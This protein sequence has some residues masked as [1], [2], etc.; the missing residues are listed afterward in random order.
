M[1]ERPFTLEQAAEFLGSSTRTLGERARKR[2]IP[3]RRPP[4]GRRLLFYPSE[5]SAWLD[6]A[7]LE[8]L[9]LPGGGRSVRPVTG[10]R[11]A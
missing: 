3:H 4:Y 11:P 10:S 7:P 1:S 8:V 5:L 6:G 2:Q 9:E